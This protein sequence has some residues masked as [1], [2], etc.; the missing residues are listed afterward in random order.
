MLYSENKKKNLKKRMK[1][2]AHCRKR[3]LHTYYTS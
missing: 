1:K 2:V 3:Q